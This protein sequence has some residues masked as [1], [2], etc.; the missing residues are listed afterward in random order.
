MKKFL[1]CIILI[2]ALAL[3]CTA[4][5][6][7]Q[8]S[9]QSDASAPSVTLL[10]ASVSL[11][12]YESVQ[13][14]ATAENTEEP[15]VWSVSD[16]SRAKVE[17]GL[18]TALAVGNVRV[19]ASAGDASASCMVTVTDS[20]AA[21]VLTVSESSLVLAVGEVF[22]VSAEAAL[23]GSPVQGAVF[24]WSGGDGVASVTAEGSVA[25]I[26]GIAAGQTEIYVSAVIR[27]VYAAS[28]VR[29]TV[30]AQGIVFDLT[31]ASP[32]LP[33]Q[34]GGYAVQL[35]TL[36]AEGYASTM[37]PALI[38]Y[39]NGQPVPD[40]AVTWVSEDTSVVRVEGGSLFAVAAGEALVR[41]SY[42]DESVL[43]RV[44]VSRTRV[45]LGQSVVFEEYGLEPA[46]VDGNGIQGTVQNI[47]FKGVDGLGSYAGGEIT[48]DAA[49]FPQE[50]AY[51]GEGE[52]ILSTDRAD[53]ILDA[54]L[55]T[56][57]IRT[58]EDFS[59]M[60]TIYDY[61]ADATTCDGYYILGNDITY[62]G[63]SFVPLAPEGSVWSRA[64]GSN[65]GSNG[66]NGITGGFKGV[67]DGK[68]HTIRG[69]TFSITPTTTTAYNGMFGVLHRDGVVQNIAF[70][71]ANI[72]GALIAYS[73]S[74]T[75]RNVYVRYA[76]VTGG[77][78]G[79]FAGTVFTGSAASGATVEACFIDCTDTRYSGADAKNTRIV[80]CGAGSAAVMNSVY[81]VLPALAS[82][83]E[84]G[85]FANVT[86]AD[87]YGVVSSYTALRADSAAQDAIASWDKEIWELDANGCPVFR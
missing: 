34:G 80:G 67:F 2:F 59:F 33:S 3:A 68:G 25:R 85:V 60:R 81:C 17:N 77:T 31:N 44:T 32:V 4:C 18:V 29:V 69:M 8:S 61:G 49:V 41:G 38:V 73:G 63:T 43:L 28:K 47:S 79:H 58:E 50:A 66:V 51:L 71:D 86:N 39:E 64:G 45:S 76:T 75:V 9:Q 62:T 30:L 35:Y 22:T 54:A 27:G 84:A 16:P 24:S 11:D 26:E 36:A 56:K 83:G 78:D 1:S 7:P 20:Q 87:V 23:K 72:C 15:I 48:L 12:L 42:K 19:T 70:T 53:Y 57:V 40:P 82:F 5:A 10:P 55:Y 52:M 37:T 21:P 13:L 6:D 74:G 14:T 46:A 65:G